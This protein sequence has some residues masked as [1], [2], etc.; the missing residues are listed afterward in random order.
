MY[1]VIALIFALLITIFSIQNVTSVNINFLMWHFTNVPLVVVILLSSLTGALV[2]FFYTLFK[3]FSL[4]R[5]ISSVKKA[6]SKLE[7]ELEHLSQLAATKEDALISEK[8][9]EKF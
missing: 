9:D 1:G 2:V 4:K 7:T 8:Q 3:T 6:H 5:E